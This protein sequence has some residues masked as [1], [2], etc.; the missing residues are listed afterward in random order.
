MNLSLSFPNVSGLNISN[1]NLIALNDSFTRQLDAV[2]AT[3]KSVVINMDNNP[4]RCD[5]DTVPFV[6][7]FQSI[8]VTNENKMTLTCSYRGLATKFI[9]Y[10]KDDNHDYDCL[11]D[12]FMRLMQITVSVVIVLILSGL[13]VGMI[14][15]KYCWHI[16]WR[17]YVMK[18]LFTRK[19]QVNMNGCN[20]QR[21]F[22]CLISHVGIKEKSIIKECVTSI[23]MMSGETALLYEKNAMPG[24]SRDGFITEAIMRSKKLLFVIGSN[25]KAEDI[26]WFEFTLRM[27]CVD[28]ALQMSDIV[29]LFWDEIPYESISKSLLKWLCKPGSHSGVRLIQ[30]ESNGMVWEEIKEALQ[31]SPIDPIRQTAN[32]EE[33]GFF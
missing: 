1:N 27:A 12:S 2:V 15:F 29:I 16:R 20:E 8:R 11:F 28:R 26:N 13:L 30:Q 4:L 25:M 3:N 14:V 31:L 24:G 33:I 18:Q 19:Q 23:E 32:S 5:C 9:L 6:R 22:L 17:W 10:V 7:W 21:E